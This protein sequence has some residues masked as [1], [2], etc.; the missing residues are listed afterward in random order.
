MPDQPLVRLDPLRRLVNRQAGNSLSDAQLVENFVA[1]RDEA[2][3]EVLVWRHGAMVLSVCKRVLRDAHEAEDAFQATFLVFARK[4]DSIGR[5]EVVAAWLYKVAYRVALRLRSAAAK[6]AGSGEPTREPAA[7]EPT[8]ADWRDL[9]PVLDDEIARLPEKYRAPFVLCY[10]QGRTNEEAAAQLGCPKGT[11]LSRLA[12]GREWLR[13]RLA[14]R[15]L[16]LTAPALALTLSQNA[17]TASVPAAL[18]LPT[19]GAAVPFAAGAAA[20]VVPA[21]IA[22]LA[23]GVLKTMTLVKLKIA[24]A[25]LALALVGSGIGWAAAGGSGDA[26]VRP[27]PVAAAAPLA[28]PAPNALAPETNAGPAEAQ[29][30]GQRDRPAAAAPGLTGK[31]VSV[32]KDGKSFT[33]ET[34]PI[35]R[36]G[37]PTKT[38]VKF[39]EK[40]A[41]TYNGVGLNGAQPTEGYAA[42]V[43]F[44]AGS[45]ELA[46]TVVFRGAETGRHG[47]D[48][49]GLVVNGKDNKSVTLEMRP[50]ARNM[51]PP[52]ESIP[53]ND[54]TVLVFSN[55]EKDG[56]K[57]T[58]GYT[59]S[60]WYADD[61]KTAAK[62]QFIGSGEPGR[63]DEKRPDTLGKVTRID[64][65]A[66]VLETPPAERGGEPT[67][68]TI[69]LDDKTTVLFHNVGPDGAKIVEGQQA[70]VWL[71]DGS[72]DK[73]AKVVF[74]GTVP[75]RWATVAGKVVAVAKDGSSFTLE[76]PSGVRGEEPKR[77]EV[78]ITAK[79]KVAFFGV[80]PD[81][82]KIVGGMMAQATL[83]DGST[84]TAAQ[85]MFAKPGGRVPG[86]RER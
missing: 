24:S 11:I 4:A 32:A 18:V 44:E 74:A 82:A 73:A 59:A 43:W 16:A 47:P 31:V 86:G 79:T 57:L 29:R 42:Q 19:V 14:R 56:A 75:E 2:S 76:Q 10:L 65:K 33:V 39:G 80:G 70:Q 23:E 69:T 7:P 20:E 51:E 45:K 46:A 1:R 38:V 81:E 25:V 58:A 85:V 13:T 41:A 48:V 9:R 35:E 8:D 83:L 28:A 40:A 36:G 71:A 6:R 30:E 66:V 26:P 12:R 50:Q 84:D 15:G 52:K 55:V 72:K 68:T 21:H 27:E 49:T 3:F 61:G 22:A 78:K 37:E 54:K 60:V 67:R 5:G 34:P 63:R 77:V 53:F 17:A 62:V 64:G